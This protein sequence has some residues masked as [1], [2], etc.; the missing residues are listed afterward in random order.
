MDYLPNELHVVIFEFF[1]YMSDWKWKSDWIKISSVS[2]KWNSLSFMA[3]YKTFPNHAIMWA[4]EYGHFD[5]VE[6][7]LK[8]TKTDPSIQHNYAI[9]CAKKREHED[10]VQLLLK[11]KRIDSSILKNYKAMM[12]MEC[13]GHL[14]HFP[15]ESG[16]SRLI[17]SDP[18]KCLTYN[19]Y[20]SSIEFRYQI[21]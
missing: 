11:D 14:G 17:K 10:V 7:L 20:N 9:R 8:N 12:F 15:E 18:K 19:C 3:F 4:S 21:K 6:R 5:V 16:V 13:H 2:K 1:L